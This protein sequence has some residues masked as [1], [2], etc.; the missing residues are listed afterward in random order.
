MYA[1]DISLFTNE[2]WRDVALIFNHMRLNKLT[3]NLSETKDISFE[4]YIN[5]NRPKFSVF[6]DGKERKTIRKKF[7]LELARFLY[8]HIKIA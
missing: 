7:I 6:A 2:T 4:P 5:T 8:M 1:D 3:L